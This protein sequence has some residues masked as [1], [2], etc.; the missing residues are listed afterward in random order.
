M[1]REQDSQGPPLLN[2]GHYPQG[3]YYRAQYQVTS[4]PTS[5]RNDT[6]PRGSDGAHK[7][8]QEY[9]YPAPAAE[10]Y[11]APA[12]DYRPAAN[13]RAPMRYA[14]TYGQSYGYQGTAPS[15][16]AA[17]LGHLPPQH[18]DSITRQLG[19]MSI[20]GGNAG[21]GN[22]NKGLG[23][24]TLLCAYSHCCVQTKCLTRSVHFTTLTCLSNS[25]T[26]A[27]QGYAPRPSYGYE[28]YAPAQSYGYE[29]YAP[30]PVHSYASSYGYGEP[31]Y[32]YGAPSYGRAYPGRY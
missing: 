27:G 32:N 25:L 26:G 13:Y 16:S 1:M 11:R 31:V 21:Y 30:A 15:M 17:S 5:W 14:P 24:C 7:H 20:A 8:V 23:T 9:D 18:R 28:S 12:A 29:S 4:C 22:V 19:V 2:E 3:D 6:H 10:Q